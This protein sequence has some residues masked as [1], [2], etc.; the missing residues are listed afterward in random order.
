MLAVGAGGRCLFIISLLFTSLWDTA[1]Y[2]LKLCLKWP[3]KSKQPTNRPFVW[4]KVRALEPFRSK[5]NN[6]PFV[7]LLGFLID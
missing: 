4:L 3:L 1:R 7:D 6:L 2:R 5:G